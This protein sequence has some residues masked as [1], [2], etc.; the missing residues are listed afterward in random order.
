MEC[1]AVAKQTFYLLDRS[2]EEILKKYKNIIWGASA[3]ETGSK[4]S[5]CG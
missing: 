1:E 4:L 3:G 2:A 5:R